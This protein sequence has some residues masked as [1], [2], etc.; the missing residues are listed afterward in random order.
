MRLHHFSKDIRTMLEQMETH[1]FLKEIK[2][3]KSN[4]NRDAFQR[5]DR[6][7]KAKWKEVN[8]N[9]RLYSF[10]VAIVAA[11]YSIVPAVINLVN[12]IQ[13]NDV[14]KR[15]VYKTYYPYMEQLKNTSPLHELF[16]CSESLSGF[17]T[18]AGVIA[19]DGLYV[20]LTMH[21][22]TLFRTL[23]DIVKETT[24]E[25]LT[26]DQKLFLLREC[27]LHHTRALDFLKRINRIFSP[28][29]LM[30]VFT[31]TSII[32]VIAFH[33]KASGNDS[34]ILVMILYLIA[35]LYQLLQFC[36]YGQRVQNESLQLPKSVYECY[37]YRCARKFKSTLNI[38]LLDVQKTVDISA[39]GLFV[40]SLETYLTIVRT[41]ASYFTALQTLTEE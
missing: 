12:L 1:H 37:W 19:F 34:Q 4:D 8:L 14:P 13:A 20:L 15:F 7:V 39:Y 29:L 21:L 35:A 22:V 40:M 33:V 27:I 38:V 11:S 9:L 31:S 17:T 5:I 16:F 32:C 3:L 26:E 18:F 24:N 25:S 30:Q 6:S 28:I 41:A 10:S 2:F 36:W 23:N